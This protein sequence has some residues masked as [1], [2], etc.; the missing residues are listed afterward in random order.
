MNHYNP[1]YSGFLDLCLKTTIIRIECFNLQQ[2]RS[3]RDDL[4]KLRRNYN[5]DYGE[6]GGKWDQLLFRTHG[7][8]LEVRNTKEVV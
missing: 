6:L 4:V 5:A 7:N 3:V 1:T 8:T 2:A